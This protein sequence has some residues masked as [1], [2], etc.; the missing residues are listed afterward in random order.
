MTVC[1][2]VSA[3]RLLVYD[4]SVAYSPTYWV[5]ALSLKRTLYF[6]RIQIPFF[7]LECNKFV[8]HLRTREL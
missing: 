6:M 3:P 5:K 7:S 2:I 1:E 4:A 8:L